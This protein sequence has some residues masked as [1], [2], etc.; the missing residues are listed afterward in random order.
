MKRNIII[1]IVLLVVFSSCEIIVLNEEP[2][3]IDLRDQYTGSYRIEEH[4]DTYG[5]ISEYSISITKSRYDEDILIIHNFYGVNIDV[6]AQLRNGKVVIPLQVVNGY[7]VEGELWH[8]PS[9]LEFEYI[10]TDVTRFH[11]ITDFCTA[12]AW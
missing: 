7:E 9:Q 8:L 11:L 1:P 5:E 10:V 2:V 4:S 3:F 6:I 12:V